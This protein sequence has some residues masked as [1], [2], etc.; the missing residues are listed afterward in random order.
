[1]D[2]LHERLGFLASAYLY[3]RYQIETIEASQPFKTF[4]DDYHSIKNDPIAMRDRSKIIDDILRLL[5]VKDNVTREPKLALQK[6]Y[7][8]LKPKSP[9]EISRLEDRWRM[10]RIRVVKAD[11]INL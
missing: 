4:L 3:S 11:E 6:A 9:K 1:L 8:L 5:K 7:K 2:A 10:E